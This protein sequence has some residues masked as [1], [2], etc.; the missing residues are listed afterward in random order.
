V[1]ACTGDGDLNRRVVSDARRLGILVGAA[2]DP[3]YCDFISPAIFRK[4]YMS[5]AVSSN[6]RNVKKSIAWR[7]RIEELFLNET[8]DE[9]EQ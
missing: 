7:D 2:D 9:K 5:V 3:E 8:G 1:F 6:A 4:G